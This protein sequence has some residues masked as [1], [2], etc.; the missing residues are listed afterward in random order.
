MVEVN[1]NIYIELLD[2]QVLAFGSLW[3]D[4]EQPVQ[5]Q[6]R[7]P[8]NLTYLTNSSVQ[9]WLNVDVAYI[10]KPVQSMSNLI[11]AV[12]GAREGIT[13]YWVRFSQRPVIYCLVSFIVIS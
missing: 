2:N 5:H 8:P 13:R 10:Q 4:L 6:G 11:R 9:E 3:D 12:T 7:H 1:L